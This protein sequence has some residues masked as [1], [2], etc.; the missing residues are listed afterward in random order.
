M[1]D[2]AIVDQLDLAKLNL[3]VN[4]LGDVDGLGNQ[5]VIDPIRRVI[6]AR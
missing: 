1:R 3:T 4:T 2:L 5:V 6:G